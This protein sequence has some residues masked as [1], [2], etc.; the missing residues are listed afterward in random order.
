M[1]ITVI[2]V[3]RNAA[4]TI[5]ATLRS[6]A[7]QTYPDIEHLIIDGA[8]TDDTL[9]IVTAEGRRVA[10]VISE[11]DAGIYDAMNKGLC[12]ATGDLVG[13][14]HADDIYADDRALERIAR[15]ATTSGADIVL[16]DILM[17][18]GEARDTVVREY[19]VR[20]FDRDW[21]EQGDM[22]PHPGFYHQRDL[23][24]RFGLYKTDYSL[25]ADYEFLTRILYKGGSSY[26]LLDG[27]P[28]VRM[29]VGGESNK[30]LLAPVRMLR[31]VYRGA[32]ENGM[33]LN[34]ARVAR[35]YFRK[36]DQ[37]RRARRMNEGAA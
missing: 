33:F 37:F 7:S 3:C 14:L 24:D 30:N 17:V 2:T 28:V 12:A 32:R 6:V 25:A 34:P 4:R 11:K 26:A 19:S 31:E 1:K 9:S 22:P 8:S 20:E 35:K 29:L 13:F 16:A 5:G 21:F 23:I 15:L 18:K 27:P 36:L 10:R